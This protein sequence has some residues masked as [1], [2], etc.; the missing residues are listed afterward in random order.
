MMGINN[1]VY[2]QDVLVEVTDGTWSTGWN[3]AWQTF[4][5]GTINSDT[6]LYSVSVQLNNP[7]HNNGRPGFVYIE[8][9]DTIDTSNMCSPALTGLVATS[10]EV[11]ITNATAAFVE[12]RFLSVVPLNPN[13]TYYFR[14]KDDDHE[15]V[16][17]SIYFNGTGLDGGSGGH[18]KTLNHI[19]K[20]VD[21]LS[22][23][24]NVTGL[25]ES[26]SVSFSNTTY[27]T[28]TPLDV[29]NN[30]TYILT[31]LSDLFP[32]DVTITSQPDTPNQV[33]SFLNEPSGN[34]TGGDVTI[35]VE[36]V[37]S[38]YSIGV[39]VNGLEKG[40]SVSFLNNG[41]DFLQVDSNGMYQFD[42]PLDD[43]SEYNVIVQSQPS[44]PDQQCDVILGN[45]FLAGADVSITVECNIVD[46]QVGVDVSG[47][48]NGNSFGLLNNGTN[49]LTVENNGITFFSQSIPDFSSY[50]MSIQS[51][52]MAPNQTCAFDAN[53]SGTINGPDN[54]V[55]ITCVTTTYLIGGSVS[56]LLDNNGL[57]LNIN[58][59]EDKIIISNGA[60]VFDTPIADGTAY[61]VIIDQQ[62]I[63]PIQPCSI[64]N[65]SDN[66]E[67]EDV[68]NVNVECEIGEDLLYINGFESLPILR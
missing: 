62:P 6:S 28:S 58:N 48:A 30:N 47:L 3:F 18:C 34:I 36:C 50:N 66:L 16:T 63:N 59:S 51:Q 12:F 64:F 5:T 33:C 57:I 29:N 27:N 43:E 35:N 40:N 23:N 2:S 46:Y 41:T 38:Q 42:T 37:T 45:D 44:D 60:Y 13:S 10:E 21:I 53:N 67:G 31:D 22:L 15:G 52:P 65:S 9:Y 49:F 68:I 61:D 11:E 7:D 24:I 1:K 14:V 56:G 55:S 26:N 4:E 54:T 8:I 25:A 32:Y 19:V 39:D 17:Q 20:T